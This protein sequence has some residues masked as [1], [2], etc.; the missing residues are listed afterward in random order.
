VKTPPIPPADVPPALGPYFSDI[1]AAFRN[2]L[3]EIAA[4]KKRL[5]DAG[6]A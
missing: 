5:K 4:L 2:L 3:A 1:E 6:I